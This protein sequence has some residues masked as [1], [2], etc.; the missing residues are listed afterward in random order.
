MLITSPD[1]GREE[2]NC[3]MVWGEDTACDPGASPGERA[4]S[5][6]WPRSVEPDEGVPGADTREGGGLQRLRM[7]ALRKGLEAEKLRD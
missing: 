4:R 5:S 7:K 2:G 6:G 1:P 3:S